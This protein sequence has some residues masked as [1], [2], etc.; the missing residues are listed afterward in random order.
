MDEARAAHAVTCVEC[1]AVLLCRVWRGDA[2]ARRRTRDQFR[3][4]SFCARGEITRALSIVRG[5]L[6]LHHSDLALGCREAQNDHAPD[7]SSSSGTMTRC[8]VALYSPPVISCSMSPMFTI[9]DPSHLPDGVPR[10]RGFVSVACVGRRCAGAYSLDVN[11]DVVRGKLTRE[12][13]V[14]EREPRH[15]GQR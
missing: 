3:V 11:D 12:G 2:H 7:A 6:G 5:A 8:V 4:I 10:Q 13:Q 15:G 1:M 9:M 14:E